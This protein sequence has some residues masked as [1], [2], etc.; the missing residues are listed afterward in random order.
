MN[1]II[2]FQQNYVSDYLGDNFGLFLVGV[3]NLVA[4]VGIPIAVFFLTLDR[5]VTITFFR[6]MDIQKKF[7]AV[8]CIFIITVCMIFNLY[9]AFQELPLLPITGAIFLLLE[10][11]RV[12]LYSACRVYMCLFRKTGL[13]TFTVTRM[14][15]GFLNC[16]IGLFFLIKLWKIRRAHSAMTAAYTPNVSSSNNNA[17]TKVILQL[18]FLYE[19]CDNLKNNY[20]QFS[21]RSKLKNL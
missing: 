16:I 18:T 17:S 21:H 3:L 19:I 11:H 13:Q 2:K 8:L 4:N 9:A 14:I 10:V 12:T 5:I 7:L 15:G 6:N 20:S 1:A